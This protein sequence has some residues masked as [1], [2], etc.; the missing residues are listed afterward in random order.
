MEKKD[1]QHTTE[2]TY[3]NWYPG[4]LIYEGVIVHH[5]PWRALAMVQY[6]D[7]IYKAY[8]DFSHP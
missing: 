4:F 8:T 7:I 6:L 2:R 5:Q 3:T 1:K